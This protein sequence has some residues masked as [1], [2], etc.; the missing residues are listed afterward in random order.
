[1][2]FNCFARWVLILAVSA[3]A[4]CSAQ[5]REPE[6][7][8]RRR[9]GVFRGSATQGTRREAICRYVLVLPVGYDSEDGGRP[10]IMVL[11]TGGKRPDDLRK[12]WAPMPE[13]IPGSEK[14]FPFILLYPQCPKDSQGQYKGW[15][16]QL[17]I[18][19]L[20]D[21]VGQCSVDEDR[22]YVTGMSMGGSGTWSLAG[23]YPERFA[24]I[25]PICGL[26]H[27]SQACRLSN[28]P[29]WAFHGAKDEVVP[30]KESI[31]MVD[32]VNRCGGKAKL[33]VYADV[34]H[35]AWTLR[36]AGVNRR[37]TSRR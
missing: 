21:I 22:V 26:T 16:E 4:G 25:A 2:R 24:A 15:S 11:H 20:D 6:G 10:L 29:V 8:S 31:E 5:Q 14:A 36:T 34:G 7:S 19:L 35:N 28:L 9:F 23:A 33:T 30:L 32:A 17:L 13:K 18:G 1:M 12:V 27:P 3:L 37:V